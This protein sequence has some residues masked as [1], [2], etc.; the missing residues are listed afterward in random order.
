MLGN[1]LPKK[2]VLKFPKT[3]AYSGQKQKE[4][5]SGNHYLIYYKKYSQR[6]GARN[7]NQFEDHIGKLQSLILMV[8]GPDVI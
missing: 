8:V 1:D 2:C 3:Q 7:L 4:M 5:F 6:N